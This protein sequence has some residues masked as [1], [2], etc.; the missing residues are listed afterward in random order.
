[1]LYRIAL[2]VFV[3]LGSAHWM[4][5]S[6]AE[7]WDLTVSAVDASNQPVTDLCVIIAST[8]E[9]SPVASFTTSNCDGDDGSRDG[10]T[11]IANLPAGIQLALSTTGA[12]PACADI[13]ARPLDP[14]ESRITL[15]LHCW[16]PGTAGTDLA[17]QTLRPEDVPASG[18]THDGAFYDDVRAVAAVQAQYAGED[19]NADDFEATLLNAGWYRSYSSAMSLPSSADSS[20]PTQRIRSYITEYVDS[21]GAAE[22]FSILENEDNIPTAPDLPMSRTFGDQSE[23]TADHGVSGTEGVPYQSLDLTFRVGNLVAGV[24][25]IV[26]DRGTPADPDQDEIE[27]L[28]AIVE[29]RLTSEARLD[30]QLGN[31]SL[32]LYQDERLA[33]T[34]DDAYYRVDG[35]DVPLTG[36]A[37]ASASDR[38]DAYDAAIDVYQLWQGI[39][40]GSPTGFLYGLSVLKFPSES[41]ASAWVT[42][43]RSSLSTNPFY[44]F[45][46]SVEGV[47]QLGDQTMALTYAAGGGVNVPRSILL[48]IRVG[49]TVMRVHLVP[50]VSQDDVPL[51]VIVP[52]A[53]SQLACFNGGAC[54]LDGAAIAISGSEQEAA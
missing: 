9:T 38:T 29:A 43:L 42:N 2:I 45:L 51:A 33:T 25:L 40:V 7:T 4:P 19:V 24:M 31:R 3:F 28:A 34:F 54:I 53:E 17:A 44:G 22:G 20:R 23:L 52:V 36:E 50:Q 8:R 21:A 1:M 14:A 46:Q 39:S 37:S 12:T 48:A 5:A 41:E 27:A 15:S 49:D 6:S 47:P 13:S 16:E 10:T 35:V 18:W 30:H 26:Y 11:S 32:R